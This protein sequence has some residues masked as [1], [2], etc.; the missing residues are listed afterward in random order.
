[1]TAAAAAA[2][3]IQSHINE[4]RAPSPSDKRGGE[5]EDAGSE[6]ARE[7]GGDGEGRWLGSAARQQL[8]V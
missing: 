7:G 4:A 2:R 1:M 8:T 5:R 3:G 6:K